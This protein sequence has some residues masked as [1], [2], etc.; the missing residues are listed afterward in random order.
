MVQFGFRNMSEAWIQ[1]LALTRKSC[2][3]AN[4]PPPHFKK[5]HG[6]EN[7]N[8]CFIYMSL[9]WEVKAMFTYC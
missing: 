1:A 4:Q 3:L 2:N 8:I 6:T 7:D 9:P 5:N